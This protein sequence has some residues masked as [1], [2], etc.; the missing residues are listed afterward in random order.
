MKEVVS[1]KFATN[2]LQFSYVVIEKFN[3]ESNSTKKMS[4]DKKG[5]GTV[6][7]TAA[8]TDVGE[9]VNCILDKTT[10]AVLSEVNTFLVDISYKIS[11]E[12][13]C[14]MP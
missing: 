9:L 12:I 10:A 14:A 7:S 3:P 6:G 5:I 13:S 4:I 11:W 1:L 8:V 2:S